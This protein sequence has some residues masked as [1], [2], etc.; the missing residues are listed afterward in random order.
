MKMKVIKYIFSLSGCMFSL[1]ASA[2]T[3]NTNSFLETFKIEIILGLSVVVC[4]V[5]IMAMY[6]T[7]VAM[8]T[9]L[10]ATYPEI[11]EETLVPVKEGEEYMSSWDRFWNRLHGAVPITKENEVITGHE[12][13]GIKELDNRLPPW[14]IYGFYLTILFGIVYLIHYHVIDTGKNQ[15]EEFEEVMQKKNQEVKEYLSAQGNLVDENNAEL[16]TESTDL[17]AGER[18]YQTN[19]A[20][21]HA[22]D[23]GGGVGPNFTD[24][25]WIHGGNMKSI[26]KTIKYGVPSKGM[27]SWENQLSPKEILQVSSF[28]YTMEGKTAQT[29]KEPQGNLFERTE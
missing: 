4:L 7:L 13:D 25:Y 11:K 5:V 20:V 8:K 1:L 27:I 18:L 6:T 29:P 19:C 10:K 2:Q 26:F 12:Y 15:Q 23:G 14:W 22:K 24:K 21:C 9:L 28:I 16:L 17:V 3:D